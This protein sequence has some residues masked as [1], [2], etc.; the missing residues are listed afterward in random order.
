MMRARDPG[1]LGSALTSCR[2]AFVGVAVMSGV[3]NVLYLTGSFFMLEVYDRVIPSRS[4]PTLIGL[5]ALALTLYAF[6]GALEA[7]RS[8]ILARV[9]AALDEALSGRVFDLVVRAPL[10]GAAPGDGLLP[11]RD[12]DQIRAFLS[13]TGPSAFFDLPWLP[14]YL[15]VCFLF[16][17]LIG[18]AALCGALFL[19]AVTWL[20]DRATRRPAQAATGH[21]LRRNGLAEAGRRNAEV[22]AALGMQG[23]FQARWAGANRDYMDAQQRNADVA[24]GLGAVSKVFRMALQSGVL[25]LGA[26]LVIQ[27][28]ATAGI[29]IASSILVSRALA[30]AELAIANWKGFVQARQSWARLSDLLARIPAGQPRHGLPAPSRTL[31]VEAVTIAPPGSQRPVVGEVSFALKAG[32]GLGV[33]GP[34]ASGKSSLIRALIGVWPPLRGKVR[35]DGAALDQ[36]EPADLGPHL[37]YLPQEAELFAGTIGENIARFDPAASAEAVIAAAQAAGIHEMVLRLTDG[38]DTRIGEGGA[39]LSS[40]QRQRIGLARA[41]YGDPFLVILDEPNANLDAEGENALTRAILGV[42]ARGGICIVVAHRPSALAALDLVLMMA[43]GRAQ[44]FGPKDEVFKR[45]L[46]AAPEPAPAGLPAQGPAKPTLQES[47]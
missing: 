45:V 31:T 25:A 12:L 17:P 21:G 23:R 34:S 11:L 27:G 32:Q 5:M 37:G 41:L 8:R 7:I 40:G 29:I 46:R 43:D 1:E 2:T 10:K 26:W 3:V 15:A 38:Y 22:L 42:R 44:A 18:V 9:G 36:W 47:A 30:P 13:G 35:L 33:I 20:T 4:V 19:A 39:G 24:G 6:Q 28:Q 14:I 16:H